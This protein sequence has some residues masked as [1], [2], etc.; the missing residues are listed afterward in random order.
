ME[1]PGYVEVLTQRLGELEE[2]ERAAVQTLKE[3]EDLRTEVQLKLKHFRAV[4][5]VVSELLR[6]E[7]SGLA[8]L[9]SEAEKSAGLLYSSFD[10]FSDTEPLPLEEIVELYGEPSVEQL[11]LA[12]M[13]RDPKRVWRAK[14][15]EK[16]FEEEGWQFTRSGIR[17]AIARLR[18][19]KKITRVERGK[20]QIGGE[21]SNADA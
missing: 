14:E 8:R 16:L 21:A 15:I 5:K 1:Q 9:W 12:H 20:Y 10:S 6:I 3:V 4:Y 2:E 19:K 18:E 17:T 11:V 13:S 7:E